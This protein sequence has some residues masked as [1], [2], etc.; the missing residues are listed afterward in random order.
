MSLKFK[1]DEIAKLKINNRWRNFKVFEVK[2]DDW[3]TFENKDGGKITLSPYIHVNH[4]K[5]PPVKIKKKTKKKKK[6]NKE[7]K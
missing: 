2:C 7:A 3:I 4:I 6:K 1:K 5:K